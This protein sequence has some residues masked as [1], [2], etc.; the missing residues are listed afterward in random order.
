MTALPKGDRGP[1][2]FIVYGDTR[3]YPDRHAAVANAMAKEQGVLFVGLSGDLVADGDEWDQWPEQ[4]FGPAKA[5]LA[6]TA[7]WPV[8]GNHEGS[9]K[10]YRAL[11]DL[12]GNEQWYSFDCGNVHVIG[13]DSEVEDG[14]ER[15]AQLVWLREDLAASRGA[16]WRLV[17]YHQPTFNIGGHASDWG[18]S[19]LQPILE[20]YEVEIAITGHSH[21]YE[22]FVPIGRPGKRPTI[23]VVSGG[24]GANTYEVRPSPL[25]EGGI[26]HS[27][28][29]YCVFDVEGSRLVMTVKH[30]DGKVLDRMELVKTGGR[31]QPEVMAKAVDSFRAR[32]LAGS[33]GGLEAEFATAP[34]PGRWSEVRIRT[35]NLPA[36]AKVS[37]GR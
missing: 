35:G 14:A 32:V 37:A 17:I 5:F 23:H 34:A 7:F 1:F 25:L 36:D 19:D 22:R 11:F 16:E 30:P 8:R 12:P 26:G 24:G 31:Y 33:L 4:F 28:L 27:V 21:L 29:H 15:A 20:E 10:L 18:A 3:S 2:R 6:Q 9:A 13:L